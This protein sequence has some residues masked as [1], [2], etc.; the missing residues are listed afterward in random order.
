MQQRKS[1]KKRGIECHLV[2]ACA[3][4]GEVQA[5]EHALC[6]GCVGLGIHTV[7]Q[8]QVACTHFNIHY[9]QLCQRAHA[10]DRHAI[11]LV[12]GQHSALAFIN[13]RNGDRVSLVDNHD[14]RLVGKERADVLKQRNLLVKVVAALE[15]AVSE[16][17][18]KEC[19]VRSA[20]EGYRMWSDAGCSHK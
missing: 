10:E 9:T 13:F 1:D 19:N 15:S 17:E 8:Q 3:R 18:Q 4:H 5:V 7:R 16:R 11:G 12:V 20:T 6:A 2:V 14:E